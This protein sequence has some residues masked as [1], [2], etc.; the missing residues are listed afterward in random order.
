MSENPYAIK[1]GEKLSPQQLFERYIDWSI[2][3]DVV[4]NTR[5]D[6]C[7]KDLWPSWLC[8]SAH[9]ALATEMHVFHMYFRHLNMFF[10]GPTSFSMNG[11]IQ[12]IKRCN[13]IINDELKDKLKIYWGI[14]SDIFFKKF[15]E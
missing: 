2:S 11:I 3:V 7:E 13:L 14:T 15:A 1:P 10:E 6:T 5:Y 8:C 4:R 9:L 12:M